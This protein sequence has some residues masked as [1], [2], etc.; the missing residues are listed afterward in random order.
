M[1]ESQ[2]K[3]LTPRVQQP[4]REKEKVSSPERKGR[5]AATEVREKNLNQAC[6]KR[7]ET[8]KPR[9]RQREKKLEWEL[10]QKKDL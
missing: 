6:R 2:S 3:D 9:R 10:E 1:E 8:E 7:A 4:R 5:R